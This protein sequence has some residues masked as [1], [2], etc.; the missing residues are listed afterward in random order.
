MIKS[1]SGGSNRT[2]YGTSDLLRS[3]LDPENNH[4]TQVFG[5]TSGSK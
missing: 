4:L 1:C 5:F 3:G 2:F